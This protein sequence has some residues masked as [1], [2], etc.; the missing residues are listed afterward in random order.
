MVGFLKL[1]LARRKKH[2]TIGA[3]AFEMGI[4]SNSFYNEVK[5]SFDT[6]IGMKLEEADGEPRRYIRVYSYRGVHETKWFRFLITPESKVR[7][8]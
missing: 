3:Y 4:H 5:V 6:V 2:G 1:H 7:V 8:Y